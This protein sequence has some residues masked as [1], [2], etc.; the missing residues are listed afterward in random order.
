MRNLKKLS[1]EDLERLCSQAKGKEKGR[2]FAELCERA[3]RL[4]PHLVFGQEFPMQRKA[5]YKSLFPDLVAM[6]REETRTCP[7]HGSTEHSV[8]PYELPTR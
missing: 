7:T 8:N 1:T 6:T 4:D 5:E 3:V 2:M